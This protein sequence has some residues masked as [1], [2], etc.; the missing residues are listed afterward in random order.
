MSDVL[1]SPGRRRLTAADSPF[2]TRLMQRG[3]PESLN[4][5]PDARIFYDPPEMIQI[6]FGGRQWFHEVGNHAIH[7][8]GLFHGLGWALAPLVSTQDE[9]GINR[10]RVTARPKRP[11]HKEQLYDM[12]FLHQ[13]EPGER[14]NPS[15][16]LPQA[17]IVT[18]RPGIVA[19]NLKTV[20]ADVLGE[21]AV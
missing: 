19:S 1:D 7:R 9:R 4:S 16:P 20:Y 13:P 12:E 2:V 17:R 10:V 3:M 14:D 18:H 15:D 6:A 21:H 11:S 5:D 8:V